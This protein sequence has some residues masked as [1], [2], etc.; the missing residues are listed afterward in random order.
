[1]LRCECGDPVADTPVLEAVQQGLRELTDEWRRAPSRSDISRLCGV[2]SCALEEQGYCPPG[3][4]YCEEL[5][6]CLHFVSAVLTTH[7]G[8]EAFERDF[9][10]WLDLL[11][12]VTGAW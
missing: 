3:E 10:P 2:I 9:L 4:D 11:A 7:V 6:G 12:Q 5:A 8:E 1:M